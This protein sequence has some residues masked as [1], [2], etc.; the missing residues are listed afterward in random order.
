MQ[1]QGV[2]SRA[3]LRQVVEQVPVEFHGNDPGDAFA[4]HLRKGAP[5]GSDFKN[6]VF[7]TQRRDLQNLPDDIGIDEKM[8]TQAFTRTGRD[9]HCGLLIVDCELILDC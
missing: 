7:R 4:Q 3:G 2:V 1:F 9:G 5:S 6:D 8:L